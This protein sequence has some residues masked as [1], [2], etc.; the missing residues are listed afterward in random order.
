[1]A[2]HLVFTCDC[3]G[4][5]RPV[6]RIDVHVHSYMGPAG[7]TDN[8]YE[9]VD[10]CVVCATTALSGLIGRQ[11]DAFRRHWV[12]VMRKVKPKAAR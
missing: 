2:E 11:D 9:R 12:G 4:A 8:D 10:L 5:E 1:M 3:C 6:G 7:S